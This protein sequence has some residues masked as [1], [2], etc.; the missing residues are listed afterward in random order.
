MLPTLISGL[1]LG[2]VY[3]LIAIGFNLTW[4]T[5]RVINFAQA[6]FTVT[7]MFLT[8]WCVNRGIPYP[9]IFL[10]LLAAG[11]LISAVEYVIAILPLRVKGNHAELITTIGVTTVIEGV[12]FLLIAE[13]ALRVPFFGSE[14]LI[15]I[16]GGRVS[17]AQIV[18]I[19]IALAIG[20]A[21]HLW[22]TR[23]RHGLA[24]LAQSEDR[25]A[26]LVLGVRPGR[27]AFF[28][29]LVSGML[30]FVVAPFVGPVTFAS[31]TL[32]ILLAVKGFVALAIGGLGSQGGALMGGLM[33]G[34]IEALVI[35]HAN[36][37]YQNIAVFVV[38]LAALILRPTGFFGQT[39]ER[40]V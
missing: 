34:L 4:L 18:L 7:G 27:I 38:F 36:S 30:G 33:I 2:S 24:A 22:A 25:E 17:P 10:I 26:A 14:A 31:I 5:G 32:A 16:P 21:A 28:A 29:F 35:R 39:Q 37:A 11:L 15:D 6:A 19:I 13:D 3:A 1:A 9:L 8:I 23:T 40:L 12:L 20:V